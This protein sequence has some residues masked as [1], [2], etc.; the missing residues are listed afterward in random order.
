MILKLNLC[1]YGTC[2]ASRRVGRQIRQKIEDVGTVEL[3]L[4]EVEVMSPSF[5]DE[6]F[7][8]LVYKQGADW[9]KTHVKVSNASE[10]IID[11]IVGAVIERVPEIGV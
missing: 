7:G 9:F 5:A 3:D 2:L 8:M 4:A 10:A 11:D 6:L 1:K